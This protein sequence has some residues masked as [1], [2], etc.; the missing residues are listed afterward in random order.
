MIKYTKRD[1]YTY[2]DERTGREYSLLE[3]KSY[4]GETTSDII[5]IW[6]LETDTPANWVY[7]AS[8]YEHDVQ[9]LDELI[10]EYIEANRKKQTAP[11]VRYDFTRA[12][13]TAF[14]R[15]VI[16]DILDRDICEW[17][18]LTHAGR[19]LRIPDTAMAYEGMET[20]L[21]EA[22]DDWDYEGV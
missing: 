10:A 21:Q 11:R 2:T 6:D 8:L 19:E 4:G 9:K 3:M 12:G 17:F 7:G 22:I 14:E 13:V 1:G 15:D 16:D 18:T 20:F 5:M